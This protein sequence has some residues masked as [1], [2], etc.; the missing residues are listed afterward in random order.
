MFILLM[1][2]FFL[3]MIAY[4]M[5]RRRTHRRQQTLIRKLYAWADHAPTLESD[6][7]RWMYRLPPAEASV[8]VD[9]LSG[10][11]SSLNWELTWLFAP[12]IERAPV[13]KHAIEESVSAYVRAILT[14]LQLENDVQAYHAY[15]EFARKPQARKQ[16]RIV[17]SLYPKVQTEGIIAQE[18]P[19]RKWGF[20][21]RFSSKENKARKKLPPRKEQIAIIQQAFEQNP[22]RMM[23]LLKQTLTDDA[24]KT[25]A[26][27]QQQILEPQQG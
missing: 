8:L 10:Y 5:Q 27:V 17:K 2:L 11:C 15:V 20:L 1:L 13:L 18:D 6:L 4:L 22:T 26:Q 23:E 19:P 24:A 16:R 25:I 12:Q 3:T 14:S 7:Q 21:P 9:L